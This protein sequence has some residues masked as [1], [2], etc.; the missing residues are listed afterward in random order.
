MAIR[1]RQAQGEIVTFNFQDN[2]AKG[3]RR[4][5]EILIDLI[6][7]I[8]DTARTVRV[9]GVDGAEK[10]LQVNGLD[11]MSGEMVNDLS[12]GKYDVTVS[13]GPSFATQRQEAAETYMAVAQAVPQAF[14][15]A[16]DLIFKAM[17]LPYS[18][19]I[20]E[21]LKMMLPPQIQQAESQGVE[22]PPEVMQ[23]MAQADQAMQ[24]VQEQAAVLEEAS[25]KMEEEAAGIEQQ[26]AEL[27]KQAA[28]L[29]VQVA[30][31]KAEV[32]QRNAELTQKEAQFTLQQAQA[33]SDEAGAQVAADRESLSVELQAAVA[34]IQQQAAQFMQQAAQTLV[35]M[36]QAA[37]PQ[38][39]VADPPKR[40]VVR[41]RRVNGELVGEV[42]ELTQEQI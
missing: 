16:G 42:Q 37:Q 35:D 9:L 20:A 7:R 40:K 32:A 24:M 12:R 11:P 3:I 22:M 30:N 28:A 2:L 26:K 5:W 33:G 15:V 19:Q 17:D 13:T 31:F 1:Q 23:A 4:T 14:G 6:P 29:S 39:V 34:A 36:Q 21:R 27:A 18:D 38:V 8:Y 25:G 41:V 10:Y